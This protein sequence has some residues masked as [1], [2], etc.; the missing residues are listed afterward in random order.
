MRGHRNF[1]KETLESSKLDVD[2]RD[3]NFTRLFGE[4]GMDKGEFIL[5]SVAPSCIF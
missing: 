5:Y 2:S 3:P 4:F 1:S